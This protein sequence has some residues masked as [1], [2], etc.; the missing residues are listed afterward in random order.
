MATTKQRKAA[1]SNVKEAQ[2]G[3]RKK[4]TLKRAVARAH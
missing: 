4:E 1:R 2:E 3:A